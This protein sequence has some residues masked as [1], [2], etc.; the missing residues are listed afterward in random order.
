MVAIDSSQ[1]AAPYHA[2]IPRQPRPWAETVRSPSLVVRISALL[3]L[4]L[5]RRFADPARVGVDLRVEQ[6]EAFPL[7]CQR[8][9][10]LLAVM[11]QELEALGL[12]AA[13]PHQLR[14]ALHVTDGHA[15]LAKPDDEAEPVQVRVAE[16]AP[17]VGVPGH[18]PEQPDAFVPAQRVLGEP[19]FLG[20]LADAPDRHGYEPMSYSAL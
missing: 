16:P 20:R 6:L 3:V 18:R 11:P 12:A 4:A 19:A 14:V 2:L 13:G 10:N 9:P 8:S 5:G 1:S 7:G 17:P 15:G